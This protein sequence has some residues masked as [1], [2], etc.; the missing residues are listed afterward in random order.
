MS[1]TCS[2]HGRV[3]TVASLDTGEVLGIIVNDVCRDHFSAYD[4]DETYLG[5]RPT[6]EEAMWLIINP[7]P[8]E[9]SA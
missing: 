7:P 1:T 5:S 4:R 8:N 3:S 9:V 6:E 2:R